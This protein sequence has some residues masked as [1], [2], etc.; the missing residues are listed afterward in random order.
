MD[1]S[2]T[3]DLEEMNTKL[4]KVHIRAWA[5]I[6]VLLPFIVLASILL[7][8]EFPVT[9]DRSEVPEG[10]VTGTWSLGNVSAVMRENG[11]KWQL[12]ISL[13]KGLKTPAA[14]LYEENGES[15]PIGQLGASGEYLFNLDKRIGTFRIY[16]PLKDRNLAEINF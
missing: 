13:S 12:Q 6:G 10:V 14:V 1:P 11:E 8:P 15:H 7:T 3:E 9:P 16:D 5:V 2:F 4:Q